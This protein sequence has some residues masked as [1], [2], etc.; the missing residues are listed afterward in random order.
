MKLLKHYLSKTRLSLLIVSLTLLV[1]LPLH[2]QS[3]FVSEEP[4]SLQQILKKLESTI[5]PG[6]VRVIPD[7]PRILELLWRH[8]N[9]NDSIGIYGWKVVVYNGRSRKDANEALAAFLNA[10]PDLDVPNGVYYPEPPDFRTLI[11]VFRTK[12]EAFALQQKLKSVFSFCYLTEV[13]LG[14]GE[15]D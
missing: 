1:A 5:Q 3:E 4:D 2:A 12:E 6:R 10:F 14:K 15:L 8:V 11:G 9:Y 7:D 13:R